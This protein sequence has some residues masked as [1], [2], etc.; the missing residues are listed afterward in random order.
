MGL[1]SREPR[2]VIKDGQLKGGN[3]SLGLAFAGPGNVLP[4][5]QMNK[6]QV[7]RVFGPQQRGNTQE[8]K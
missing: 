3:V 2:R 6:M 7:G 4:T 5:R 8:K 1:E